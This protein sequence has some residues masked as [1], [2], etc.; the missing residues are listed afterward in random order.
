WSVNDGVSWPGSFAVAACAKTRVTGAGATGAG[1][2][3]G[4]RVATD[5]AGGRTIFGTI[6]SQRVAELA[7]R[8]PSAAPTTSSGATLRESGAGTIAERVNR[9]EA[10]RGFS[11][12]SD[13]DSEAGPLM[14]VQVT[15]KENQ[16][17]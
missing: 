10:S 15:G 12:T 17:R 5:L 9:E 13:T 6:I 1:A 11:A 14:Y 7:G 2:A 8:M 4:L 3:A 16:A